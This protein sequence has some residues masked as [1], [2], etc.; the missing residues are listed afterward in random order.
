[1]ARHTIGG[2]AV[3]D[4]NVISGNGAGIGLIIGGPNNPSALIQNNYIGVNAAGTAAIGNDGN[5]INLSYGSMT[6]LGNVISGN[7]GYGIYGT[8]TTNTIQGN[9]IGLSATGTARVG[10]ASGGIFIGASLANTIGGNA[11]GSRNVISGN[12][13]AGIVWAGPWQQQCSCG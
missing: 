11:E 6:A 1:M 10:N 13:G 4:R 3:A 7:G 9:V 5:G 8:N 12:G 2:P